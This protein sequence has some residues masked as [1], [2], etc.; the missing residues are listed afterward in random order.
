MSL[1]SFVN[2]T[3]LCFLNFRFMKFSQSFVL[4]FFILRAARAQVRRRPWLRVAPFYIS[5]L[6]V[7]LQSLGRCSDHKLDV[8]SVIATSILYSGTKTNSCFF[9]I[10]YTSFLV[11]K[12]DKASV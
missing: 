1:V 12:K 11:E 9:L 2:L 4:C 3:N 6:G 8:T 10:F 5:R 7:G